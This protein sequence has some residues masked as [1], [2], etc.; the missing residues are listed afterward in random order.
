MFAVPLASDVVV[1]DNG[2]GCTVSNVLPV[3]PPKVAEMLLGPAAIVVARPLL[4]IVARAV[5]DEAHVAVE[6]TFCVLES[7]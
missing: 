6:V 4:L 1:T 7:E 5:T 3:T 2:A